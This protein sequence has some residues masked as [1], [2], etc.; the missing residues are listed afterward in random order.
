M[1]TS[2]VV[3]VG[4]LS[5]EATH[6]RSSSTLTTDA[7]VD[8]NGLGRTFSPTDLLA[9]SLASCMLT[10][11]GIRANESGLDISGTRAEVTKI[12]ASNPRRVAE[13]KVDLTIAD[14]D[15]TEI[16]KKVLKKA[17]RTCPVALSL[18][19]SLVQSVSFTYRKLN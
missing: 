11:M 1:V 17:A 8:N 2:E 14:R 12:M 19:E 9:T 6:L 4:E 13:V 15:L 3:Y 7:P 10:I 5:T 18:N 16:Q